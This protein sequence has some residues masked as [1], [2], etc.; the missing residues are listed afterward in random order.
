MV[1]LA[2]T[3]KGME[4]MWWP[5]C[6]RC[7][8]VIGWF[9]FSPINS[10]DTSTRWCP[11]SY[12]LLISPLTIDI[13]PINHSYWRYVHQLSY[14]TGAPPCTIHPF[15]SSQKATWLT[16]SPPC[17]DQF[18]ALH[19]ARSCGEPTQLIGSWVYPLHW[20]IYRPNFLVFTGCQQLVKLVTAASKMWA[21]HSA[22]T[23]L[24]VQP[25]TYVK[26]FQCFRS[27]FRSLG[28]AKKC[29][30]RSAHWRFLVQNMSC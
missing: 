7:P 24:N 19:V 8:P 29:E 9:L 13:S 26:Y 6:R 20:T 30:M 12:K 27:T 11:P 17:V 16:G 4:N 1:D 21:L 14:R 22:T 25:I 18:I 10:F 28:D 5:P 2:R 23:G 15:W 3:W